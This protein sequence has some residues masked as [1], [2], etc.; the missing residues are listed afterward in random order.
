MQTRT[1]PGECGTSLNSSNLDV[2]H[3]TQGATRGNTLS[4][5]SKQTQQLNTVSTMRDN[6]LGD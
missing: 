4:N 5:S 1:L 2:N 6:M 3:D